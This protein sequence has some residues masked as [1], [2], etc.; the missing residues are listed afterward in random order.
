VHVSSLRGA[1]SI[2]QPNRESHTHTHCQNNKPSIK[3]PFEIRILVRHGT[4]LFPRSLVG[5]VIVHLQ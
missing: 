3:Y 2:T 5:G 1:R 4:R